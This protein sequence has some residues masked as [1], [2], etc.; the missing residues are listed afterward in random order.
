MTELASIAADSPYNDTFNAGAARHAPPRY[1]LTS[2]LDSTIRL[3]EVPTG[4]C[5]NTFFGHVEGVWALAADALRVVS[6]AE[7]SMVKVWDAR[8]GACEKTYTGHAGPV[9]CVGLSDS[10]MCSGGEDGE[11]RMYCFKD[12][13]PPV[14]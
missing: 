10:R 1:I 4:R 2:A 8:T 7:D 12:D 6:G 3:W 14:N 5:V 9:P 11:V 13:P